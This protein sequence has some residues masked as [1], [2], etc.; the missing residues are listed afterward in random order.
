MAGM[1]GPNFT[2]LGTTVLTS[3]FQV[4]GKLHVLGVLQTFINDE[5]K[6][7]LV[8]Y[9]ADV[10]GFDPT[11]PA[12]RMSQAEMI[13][14]KRHATIVALETMPA[15]GQLSLLTHTEPL[16]LYTDRFA[17]SGKFHMGTDARVYDFTEVSL[18][19]YIAASDVKIY[20]LFQSRPGLVQAAPVVLIQKSQIR[21]YHKT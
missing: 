15:Q 10:L 18:Q 21:M 1:T 2:E 4:R 16:M 19:Q 17:L 11:N 13:V 6:P 3:T 8:V 20:P 14:N 12:A 5:Q 7:M 9:S